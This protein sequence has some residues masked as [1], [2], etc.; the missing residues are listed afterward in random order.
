MLSQTDPYRIIGSYIFRVSFTS[1]TNKMISFEISYLSQ[2]F[3][4]PD[5]PS[6]WFGEIDIAAFAIIFAVSIIISI[7]MTFLINRARNRIQ[8]IRNRYIQPREDLPGG[9]QVPPLYTVLLGATSKENSLRKR[10]LYKEKSS[11]H[12]DTNGSQPDV[13]A[14]S[15]SR[16]NTVGRD[17]NTWRNALPRLLKKI[18]VSIS[19]LDIFESSSKQ[20]VSFVF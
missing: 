18:S 7:A 13:Q 14:S 10:T 12:L 11:Q 15:S 4:T 19:N 20:W 9:F 5:T 3:I 2:N 8:N 16:K 1:S 17:S 6:S